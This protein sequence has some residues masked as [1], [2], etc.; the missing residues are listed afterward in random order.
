MIN[1]RLENFSKILKA[2]IIA[3]VISCS[4]STA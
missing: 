4:D 2:Q 1:E 3:A